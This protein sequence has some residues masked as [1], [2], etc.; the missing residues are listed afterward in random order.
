M[1]YFLPILILL[2]VACSKK[3]VPPPLIIG[4]AVCGLEMVNSVFPP[5]T[6]EGLIFAKNLGVEGYEID[7]QIDSD[8]ELWLF[9]DEF[10]DENTKGMGCINNLSTAE[11]EK[12]TYKSFGK[13]KLTRLEE[14]VS[15]FDG[16]KLVLLDI[17]HWNACNETAADKV[18]FKNELLELGLDTFL[19][20]RLI[21]TPP[22]W[23]ATFSPDFQVIASVE[24]PNELQKRSQQFP[25]V[26][27][28][29]GSSKRFNYT[30]ITPY[31]TK[32]E[33]YLFDLRSITAIR[34]SMSK[35]AS[36][37]LVDDLRTGIQLKQNY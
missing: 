25:Q 23:I 31:K 17:K 36:G 33:F 4:H 35:G 6:I 2:S 24:N 18:L 22:S 26:C 14:V 1:K 8:G 12:I 3:K 9:H 5:N 10:L 28:W 15:F 37:I 11:I 27:G 13:E 30:D 20:V 7:V 32:Y 19:N 34:R 21:I 16:K 29:L